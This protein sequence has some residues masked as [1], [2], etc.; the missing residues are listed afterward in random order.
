M[1]HIQTK[2][3]SGPL[4]LLLELIL[5]KDLAITDIALADVTEEYL[6]YLDREEVPKEELADFL[7]VAA[8]LMYLKSNAILPVPLEEEPDANRLADQLRRYQFFLRAGE[9][10]QERWGKGYARFPRPRGVWQKGKTDGLFQDPVITKEDLAAAFTRVRNRLRPFF[11]LP[12]ASL[13]RVVSVERRIAELRRI[14]S[15]RVRLSFRD[16]VHG[17]CSKMEVVVSFLALL[18]LMKRR[19]VF[20]LQRDPCG[21]ITLTHAQSSY[22]ERKD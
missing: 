9:H 17:A 13:E 2:I 8:K 22:V 20:A 10:M 6:S 11:L 12:Q 19:A 16:L 4:D 15:E 3:L 7:G 14:F 18:E 21:E 1:H 5:K